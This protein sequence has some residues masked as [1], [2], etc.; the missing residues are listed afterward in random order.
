MKLYEICKHGCEST[1]IDHKCELH[2][3]KC[4]VDCKECNRIKVKLTWDQAMHE[5]SLSPMQL[6][7][8]EMKKFHELDNK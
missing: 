1:D 4:A 5:A 8:R 2:F 3:N 7:N 6:Y